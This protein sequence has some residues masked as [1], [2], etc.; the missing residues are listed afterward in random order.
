MSRKAKDASGLESSIIE[1]DKKKILDEINTKGVY[2]DK[3]VLIKKW[4]EQDDENFITETNKNGT[5]FIGVLNGRLERHGYGVN[6]YKSGEKYLGY[7]DQDLPNKHGI[8]L[9]MEK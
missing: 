9:I 5:R 8:Y 2:Q 1:L 7:F 4:D 6:F 3:G